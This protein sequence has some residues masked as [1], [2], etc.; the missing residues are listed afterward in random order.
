MGLNCIRVMSCVS[1][2]IVFSACQNTESSKRIDMSEDVS[3]HIEKESEAPPVVTSDMP[4][5]DMKLDMNQA[6][7]HTAFDLTPSP[8]QAGLDAFA[9]ILKETIQNTNFMQGKD[10]DVDH[11]EPV[12][13]VFETTVSP[14]SCKGFVTGTKFRLYYDTP[15]SVNQVYDLN[16]VWYASK[17]AR[18]EALCL[19]DLHIA[20]YATYMGL[21]E[22]YTLYGK[23][24]YKELLLGDK[25]YIFLEGRHRFDVNT[26]PKIMMDFESLHTLDNIPTTCDPD[27]KKLIQLR[28]K[29]V[30]RFAH[31]KDPS[32]SVIKRYHKNLET[33]EGVRRILRMKIPG[34]VEPKKTDTLF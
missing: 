19:R 16:L 17:E 1:V 15:K 20:T 6:D 25:G 14:E 33:L 11:L 18:D 32:K 23:H 28:R 29:A 8:E 21:G 22:F 13:C 30:R 2:F 9:Q 27:T 12:P 31:Y 5:V 3:P 34:Y 7:Q 10:D 24:P 26:L 4:S